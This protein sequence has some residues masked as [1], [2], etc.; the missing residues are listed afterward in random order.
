MKYGKV[1]GITQQLFNKN[2]VAIHR[3]TINKGS[4]C[5]EHYHDY[6]YNMFYIEKG[7]LLIKHWQTDYDL[8]DETILEDGE[9]STIPP[10]HF[11]QFIAL[12]DT[13]AY[14]IYYVELSDNDINRKTC[15]KK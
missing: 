11:H 4:S 1:W 6:K 3:I 13:I 2:N 5:S 14:E 10:K 9:S 12:E 8:V 15:G 7:K